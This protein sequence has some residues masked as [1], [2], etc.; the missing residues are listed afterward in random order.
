MKLSTFQNR[1]KDVQKNSNGYRYAIEL[2]TSGNRVYTC[3]TSGSGRFTS[4]IDRTGE[5]INVLRF[6]GLTENV[7][8]VSGNDAPRGGQ[9]GNYLEL[10]AKGRRKMVK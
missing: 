5:T 4:N 6:A 2:L 3:H 10:T 9:T 7:D 8:F 1:T